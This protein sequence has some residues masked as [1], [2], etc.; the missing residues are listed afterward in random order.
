MV[1]R[2]IPL[3]LAMNEYFY[4]VFG[5]DCLSPP[6]SGEASSADAR[7][8]R[9]NSHRGCISFGYFSLGIQRKVIQGRRGR[10]A[11]QLKHFLKGLT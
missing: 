5:E 8:M 11:P 9:M 4:G 3:W 7:K 1:C 10:I 2:A 6:Q